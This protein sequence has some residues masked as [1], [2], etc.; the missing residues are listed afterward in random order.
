MSGN[1]MRTAYAVALV[2]SASCMVALVWH[3][4]SS[5]APGAFS[6]IAFFLTV[7]M[8]PGSFTVIGALA[9]AAYGVEPPRAYR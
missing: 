8:A 2:T 6:K 4:V 9:L 7:P 1:A 5:T 3:F